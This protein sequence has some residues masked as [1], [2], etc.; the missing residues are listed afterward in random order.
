[1]NG[2]RANA[3]PLLRIVGNKPHATV[4][5]H[6][7]SPSI[8]K[9]EARAGGRTSAKIS[10]DATS[11]SDI[12]DNLKDYKPRPP[13]VPVR[14]PKRITGKSS[15]TNIHGSGSIGP[16]ASGRNEN[17]TSR[18][19]S[20]MKSNGVSTNPKESSEDE[21]E[22]TVFSQSQGSQKRQR[23][24]YGKQSTYKKAKTIGFRRPQ[25][26]SNRAEDQDVQVKHLTLAKPAGT[27][28]TEQPDP[29]S[30]AGPVFRLP[31]GRD[32]A[33]TV[34][35][36]IS[37][38]EGSLRSSRSRSSSLSSL[39]TPEPEE[40][41]VMKVTKNNTHMATSP[42]PICGEQVDLSFKY[43]FQ[44][45]RCGGRRMNFRLQELFCKSHKE[46]AAKQTWQ[47]REYPEI[48]W[49]GLHKRLMKH[50]QRIRDVLC[51]NA[52]SSYRE[53]LK[54]RLQSG[55]SKTAMQTLEN[56]VQNGSQVG[57]YGAKG[58]EIM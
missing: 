24:G 37:K 50:N 46:R 49:D 28:V 1:M 10:S 18:P 27:G 5:D 56:G 12:E 39:S 45:E 23:A 17:V 48:D 22:R 44:A 15:S 52:K 6:K 2:L 32:T 4:S 30:S 34:A 11:S 7:D 29:S 57:Y 8:Q 47:D 42:C 14:A 3:K 19:Q 13:R 41:I 43:D 31:V 20:E 25:G 51:S 26:Q 16:S 35:S 55:K 53:E 33:S 36:A 21:A 40:V 54:E 58:G 9:V 38:T